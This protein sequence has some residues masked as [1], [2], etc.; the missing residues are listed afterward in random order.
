MNPDRIKIFTGTSNPAL[1]RELCQCLG[2]ELGQAKLKRFADGEINHADPRKR[3]RRGLFCGPA[4]L[5]RR[6]IPT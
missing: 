5:L 4:D 6:S 1:A 3:P 2:L